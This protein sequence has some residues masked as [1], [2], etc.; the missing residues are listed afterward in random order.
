MAVHLS[1]A[2]LFFKNNQ[3]PAPAKKSCG[4]Q[5]VRLPLLSSDPDGVGQFSVAQVLNYQHRLL[6]AIKE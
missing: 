3:Q 4:T 6:K 2:S 5:N 1:S